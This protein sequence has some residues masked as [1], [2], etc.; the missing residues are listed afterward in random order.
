MSSPNPLPASFWDLVSGLLD[1]HSS[2]NVAASRLL[3]AAV[4]LAAALLCYTSR[5]RACAH[6]VYAW[7]PLPA[8]L[9]CS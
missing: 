6:R 4:L 9:P 5:V 1:A 7:K 3:L 8:C 2:H